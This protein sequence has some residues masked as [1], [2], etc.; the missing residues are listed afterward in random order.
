MSSKVQRPTFE[1]LMKEIQENGKNILG[2]T[3]HG[4]I[5]VRG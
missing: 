2:I 3:E 4:T 5:V 1:S